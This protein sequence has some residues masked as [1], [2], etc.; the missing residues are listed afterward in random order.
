[1]LLQA[2][3]VLTYRR[4]SFRLVCV[5]FLFHH[6]RAVLFVT[7][8]LSGGIGTP[9]PARAGE[10]PL[11]IET[12]A[13]RKVSM[14][15]SPFLSLK[16][17]LSTPKQIGQ[18]LVQESPATAP[19]QSLI[20]GILGLKGPRMTFL[21]QN[22]KQPDISAE[23]IWHNTLF[24]SRTETGPSIR[25]ASTGFLL[26][27]FHFSLE[28]QTSL[29]E[30]DLPALTRTAFVAGT[31]TRAF[32]VPVDGFFSFRFNL[33]DTLE[34][35]SLLRPPT[36]LPVRSNSAFFAQNPVM[37]ETAFSA[38]THSF[39]P[40]LHLSLI[41]GYLEE[42]YGG[43]G[44]ELLYRPFDSRFA[45]GAESWL[46]MKRDPLSALGTGFNGDR[47][48]TGHLN[49][50]YDLPA[51]DITLKGSL[52]QYL[53]TDT[54]GS[55]GF[56]K[57]FGLHALDAK[58]EGFVTLTDA[59]DTD[60]FATALPPYNGLR[61]S[62]PLGGLPH[63]PHNTTIKAKL[64]P[65]GRDNGQRLDNPLPLYDLTE[66]FSTRHLAD[67]WSEI[68]DTSNENKT[69]LSPLLGYNQAHKVEIQ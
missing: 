69:W 2:L 59:T 35:L 57:R 37:L 50:W 11:E 14:T 51:W 17:G 25:T 61:L 12:G 42:M 52:G 64:A 18:R 46:A 39:G 29:P 49:G 36:A 15:A 62:V 19:S 38:Y 41:G 45:V 3:C 40:D 7:L 9:F 34:P 47:V 30:A 60:A 6:L 67:H 26:D 55:L 48:L 4:I 8:L 5:R 31:D 66:A 21:A 58:L 43:F 33:Q 44:G 28:N 10:R 20:L 54:G 68:K 1:M 65:F 22:F 23:E 53:N 24:D 56:E 13:R 27:F 32:P 16:A 63:V